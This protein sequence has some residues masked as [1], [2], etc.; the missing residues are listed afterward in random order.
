MNGIFY[1]FCT[2]F[3]VSRNFRALNEKLLFYYLR[4]YHNSH[5]FTVSRKLL[6]SNSSFC[7]EKRA[8]SIKQ[9]KTFFI[10]IMFA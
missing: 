2:E 9:W 5:N 4:V 10:Q 1:K 6:E 8:K 3:R 7:S